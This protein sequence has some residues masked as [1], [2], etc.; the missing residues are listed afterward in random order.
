M[1]SLIDTDIIIDGLHNELD[2]QSRLERLAPSGLAISIISL[3]ELLEGAYL[4][5]D[6]EIHHAK[7]H[8]FLRGFQVLGLNEQIM[9]RFARERARLR[10]RGLLIA[11]FDLLFAATA[12][13]YSLRLVTRNTRHFERIAGLQID[14]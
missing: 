5:S 14:H 13:T 1:S 2:A 12:L 9:H 7:L 3:G 11:D 8:E 6:P 4:S 10:R